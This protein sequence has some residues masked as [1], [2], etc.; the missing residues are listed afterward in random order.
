MQWL[1]KNA[2][3]YSWIGVNHALFIFSIGNFETFVVVPMR[4]KLRIQIRRTLWIHGYLCVKNGRQKSLT[5]CRG[6]TDET[7]SSAANKT[8]RRRRRR[9]SEKRCATNRSGFTLFVLWKW[10]TAPQQKKRT[11]KLSLEGKPLQWRPFSDRS[12]WR[13]ESLWLTQ[14]GDIDSLEEPYL[15]TWSERNLPGVMPNNIPTKLELREG[16]R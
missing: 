3:K 2:W 7:Q 12:I 6:E 9:P 10:G 8:F 15:W 16:N 4:T 13:G 1:G 14:A 11:E 5:S